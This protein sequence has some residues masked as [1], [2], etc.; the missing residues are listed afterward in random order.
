MCKFKSGRFLAV[1]YPWV[2]P[3]VGHGAQ[4]LFIRIPSEGESPKLILLEGR[5][6]ENSLVQASKRYTRCC[7]GFE[8]VFHITSTFNI[9]GYLEVYKGLGKCVGKGSRT[10]IQYRKYW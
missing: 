10:R 6:L 2:A 4:G 9:S 3:S 8:G 1:T 7:G 5:V